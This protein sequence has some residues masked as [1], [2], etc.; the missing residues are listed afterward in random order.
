[1]LEKIIERKNLSFEESYELFD[2]LLNENEVK[3][4]AYLAAI[5]TKGYTAEEIAGLAKAMRDKALKIDFGTVADTCGTGGDKASTINIS[6][7]V[8]FLL[9]CF[10]R[11]AKHGN[12]SVTSKSGSADVLKALG[13]KI[14]LTPE[15][16]R[17]CIEKTNFTFLFAPLYHP[18]LRKIMPVRKQ[19]GIKT[20]FNILGPLANPAEPKFQLVGVN[21][22]ELLEKVAEALK[23]LRVKKA[24]VVHGSGLDEVNPSNETLVAE[25]G[26]GIEMYRISPEDFGVKKS[27]IIRCK[28]SQESAERII[29]VFSGEKNDDANFILVNASAALYA[30]EITSSFSEGVEITKNAIESGDALKKFLEVRDACKEA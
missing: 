28:N 27:K 25:V 29:K 30:A 21:S 1:M 24:L 12:V 11:V 26:K 18:A 3:V 23:L 9:S 10:T 22:A 16:A 19:L 15:E 14:D 6:T 7:A 2:C 4:A 17:K 20:V 5:Q 8:A 13:M